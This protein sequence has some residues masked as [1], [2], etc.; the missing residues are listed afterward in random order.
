M[1][2]LEISLLGVNSIF[3]SLGSKNPGQTDLSLNDTYCFEE[4]C[5]QCTVASGNHISRSS[6][7]VWRTSLLRVWHQEECFALLISLLISYDNIMFDRIRV[8]AAQVIYRVITISQQENMTS[9]YQF[10]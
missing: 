8:S 6:C 7:A 9:C 4:E 3:L 5:F 10:H 1:K 2:D